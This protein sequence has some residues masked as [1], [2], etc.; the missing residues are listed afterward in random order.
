LVY[1]D[2]GK[3][4]YIY[5]L[6]NQDEKGEDDNNVA[7]IVIF[8]VILPLIVISVLGYFLYKY[9]KRK[10]ATVENDSY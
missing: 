10:R 2:D 9:I 6:Y 3:V 1:K 5:Y 7:V 8:G 4:P